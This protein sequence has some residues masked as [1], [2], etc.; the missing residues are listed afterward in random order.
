M[1]KEGERETIDHQIVKML[2]KC[3]T[4]YDFPGEIF[5]CFVQEKPRPVFFGATRFFFCLNCVY[6]FK[7]KREE[8]GKEKERGRRRRKNEKPGGSKQ[9]KKSKK[10]E[11][12][13]IG[14][15]KILENEKTNV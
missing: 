5:C 11:S 13:N 1:E 3:S 7:E 4:Q 12:K 6:F 2:K 15:K 14:K 10:S 9:K 8:R